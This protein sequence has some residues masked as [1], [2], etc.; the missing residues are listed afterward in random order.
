LNDAI[1]FRLR[2]RF[3]FFALK[4]RVTNSSLTFSSLSWGRIMDKLAINWQ[5]FARVNLNLSLF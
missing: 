3:L 1:N 5:N 4:I 2:Y